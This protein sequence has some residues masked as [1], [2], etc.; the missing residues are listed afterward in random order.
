MLNK[1]KGLLIIGLLLA[2]AGCSQDQPHDYGRRRPD[3]DSLDDRDRGL[4]SKDVVNAS[5]QMARDLLADE[6]LRRS[7]TQ[8]TMVVDRF[9][10]RT[11]DRKF[12]VNYD[13]FIERLR[14]NISKY[15]KG[16]VQ[17]IENKAKLEQLRSKELDG[18]RDNFGQG[19]GAQPPSRIQPDFALYGRAMDLPNRGTN[20][21]LLE[22]TATDLKSGAQVWSNQYEVKVS[23]H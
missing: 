20:Y 10:D 7:N 17:L 5:D 1:A 16:S 14:T 13:I 11:I 15:G 6:A 12:N 3:V 4:Q 8:W 9:E 23:R 19:G 21:Y 18:G 2:A 22:F